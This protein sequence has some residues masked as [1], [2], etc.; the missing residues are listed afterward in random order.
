MEYETKERRWLESELRF[1]FQEAFRLKKD[2]SDTKEQLSVRTTQYHA[3]EKSAE[4][5]RLAALKADERYAA[6]E[7]MVEEGPR[8]L[9]KQLTDE[10]T[11]LEKEISTYQNHAARLLTLKGG[12][13]EIISVYGETE[14]DHGEMAAIERF[15]KKEAADERIETFHQMARRTESLKFLETSNR[16]NAENRFAEIDQDVTRVQSEIRKQEANIAVYPEKY[17]KAKA[18]ISTFFKAKGLDVPV[19][20]FAELVVSFK[21][22]AWQK[23]IES[24][25]GSRRFHL[26]I[27]GAHQRE[28]FSVLMDEKIYGVDVVYTDLLPSREDEEEGLPS[29]ASCL[30]IANPDARNYADYLLGNIV[31]CET[32]K[33]LE[34][35]VALGKGGLMKNGVAAQR[36]ARHINDLRRLR[37]YMGADAAKSQLEANRTLLAELRTEKRQTESL[38][39][40]IRGR[41][42]V[43][44]KVK[45]VEELYDFA[46]FEALTDRE[47]KLRA[48]IK[49]LKA[50]D[51]EHASYFTE[52]L[53]A[54]EEKKKA[55]EVRGSAEQRLGELRA[56][57]ANLEKLIEDSGHS[58]RDAETQ[59][60]KAA[61][62][63]EELR[64]PAIQSY[65]EEHRRTGQVIVLKWNTVT[66]NKSETERARDELM[67]RQ[68]RYRVFQNGGDALSQEKIGVQYIPEFRKIRSRLETVR[69]EEAKEKLRTMKQDMQR[70][71]INDFVA[72]I[73]ENINEAKSFLR[74]ENREL[75]KH[76]F[77]RDYY[78]F[79]FSEAADKQEFFEICRKMSI[80]MSGD[81]FLAA[82]PEGSETEEQLL[83]FM[84]RVLEEEDESEFTDYRN[85]L[86]YD[87]KIIEPNNTYYLS[88]KNGSASNGEKQTPYLIILAASLNRLY[89]KDTCCAR[90]AFMD[91]AFA[92]FSIER[93][94]QM[95]EYFRQYGFQVIYAA[96]DKAE[97]MIGR[98]MDAIIVCV[99]PEGRMYSDYIDGTIKT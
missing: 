72:T 89:P 8:A 14:F 77:D 75:R 30:E 36:F 56:E 78:E 24:Y 69:L 74:G 31:L 27:D 29:A 68:R 25:L 96:P 83:A 2:Q 99:R 44:E 4:E 61:A 5:A 81:A 85:Y 28:A 82:T 41:L 35:A 90:L 91:E 51:D 48:L 46:A 65:E 66:R 76:P 62:A 37:I 12:M 88:K 47:K 80:Y 10:K 86:T 38:L 79:V 33:E 60:E 71:F 58:I 20:F 17:E 43:L 55:D 94:N 92:A 54:Q 70:G 3:A 1:L 97:G 42:N 21:D 15:D 50:F 98:F 67:S 23:V 57:L 63:N 34:E 22:P 16:V 7:R 40:E 45:Y 93:I 32:E 18:A 53:K 87:L 52:L 73:E 26:I 9:R 59:F 95:I 6:V 49:E 84:N 64:L 11:L 39:R 13:Q 19:R